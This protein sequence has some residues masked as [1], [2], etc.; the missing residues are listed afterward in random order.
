MS[1]L[2]EFCKK[3]LN[4][5]GYDMEMVVLKKKSLEEMKKLLPGCTFKDLYKDFLFTRLYPDLYEFSE[6][7]KGRVITF[8]SK[9]IFRDFFEPK[10]ENDEAIIIDEETYNRML[11]WLEEKLK[12]KTLYDYTYDENCDYLEFETMIR[13]YKQMKAEKIVYETEFVVYQHDW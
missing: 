5:M 12:S 4:N 11:C 2:Q 9:N 8:S 7:E 10:L 1:K 3:G 13:V 6:D